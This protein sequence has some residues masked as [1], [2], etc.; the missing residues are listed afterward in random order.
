[1]GA[2]SLQAQA[3][4]DQAKQS[5]TPQDPGVSGSS[6]STETKARPVCTTDN[7]V[8]GAQL[9]AI[10]TSGEKRVV[11]DGRL[12]QEGTVWDSSGFALVLKD[13]QSNVIV[14]IGKP[15][16]LKALV[17]Q[18]DNNDAY[19]LESSLDGVAYQPI[20][21][22]PATLEGQG[23]RTRYITLAA[24]RTARYLRVTGRGGDNYYSISELRAYCR[25]PKAWPPRLILPPKKHGWDAID[26]DVMVAIKGWLAV[27]GSLILLGGFIYR[28]AAEGWRRAKRFSAIQR[29]DDALTALKDKWAFFRWITRLK[30]L[31]RMRD[32]SLAAVGF[33]AFISWWNIG[34]FHFD[35]YIHIW[36]HYHYYIGAKYG[37]ELRY[38]RLYEC[39]AAADL[40]DGLY[41]R[42]K[43]RKMRDLVT[44]ELGTTD[45]I[46]KDP[47]RCK[48]HFSA[49][50][51]E[52]F[53]RDIRWFR[54]RF[55]VDRWNQSQNDHGY[56][57]TPVWAILARTLTDISDITWSTTI[58]LEMFNYQ[59]V[60]DK[61]LALGIIDSVLL[62]IMWAVVWWAFGWR[63]TCVA[64]LY[65]GCNFPARYYWNGGS[66]L[67]YDWLVWMII[68]ICLLKKEKMAS[69]GFALT[70]ATLLRVFPGMVVVALI[71]KALYQMVQA[72][73]FFISKP[74]LRFAVG[75]IL[76]LL[77]FIPLS[78]WTMNGLDAWVEFAEN[79]SKHLSTPLTNNMGL[80]TV[81]GYD[82]AT[83]AIRMRDDKLEDPFGRWKD[84]RR[85]YYSARKPLY[86]ALIVLFL[87]ML[88]KAGAKGEDWEAAALGA[89]MIAVAAEL[90]C[91][92]Y[93]FLLTYGFF[94][95]KRRFPAIAVVILAAV[96]CL[97]PEIWGWNDD[98][99]A[100]MSLATVITVY[101]VTAQ[102]A[103]EGQNWRLVF[104][105]LR[106]HPILRRFSSANSGNN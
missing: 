19:L 91:Y 27:L 73:R 18:A 4:D 68:G 22:A 2:A 99:F 6:A 87:V 78:S 14:D 34:H 16:D 59:K 49:A 7:L 100:A 52:E 83:R 20:W 51:W 46:I 53:K 106:N 25:V 48:R 42:V 72:R 61:I 17:L 11:Q 15:S 86:I 102:I 38:S 28:Y 47:S 77:I 1:M 63:A 26:N 103:F 24:A 21:T 12:A 9:F 66:F 29:F 65:W 5:A 75:C 30:T 81:L 58:K 76:A 31:R 62:I 71:A 8:S 56:N 45:A 64:L 94:W 93:G 104:S 105:R 39:T 67:R 85:Y 40:E 23:L 70:Y 36:E 88:G 32:I 69:G 60:V 44:N 101:T 97:F 35:H 43:E 84:A 92:Y 90:T 41:K 96:T 98:H 79:S 57:G 33:I 37:P 3:T 13:E 54:A 55:S 80:K 10:A 95:D 50:R 74:Q 89:G 82:F